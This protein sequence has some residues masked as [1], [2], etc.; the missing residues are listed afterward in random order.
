VL[1]KAAELVNTS[2]RGWLERAA[3]LGHLAKGAIYALVGVLALQ[4]ALGAGG[5]IAGNHEAFEL[6]GDQPFGRALLFLIAVGL[7]GYALWRVIEA[8]GGVWQKPRGG[9]LHRL[10]ALG[11]GLVNGALSVAV[12][13]MALGSAG[14][15]SSEPRS[16]VGQLL[17]QPFGEVALALVGAIIIGVGVFQFYQAYSKKFLE[18]FRLSKMSPDE[19]RWVTRAGQAGLVARGV[20]FPIVGAG[21]LRAAL[22]HDPSKTRDTRAA[23]IE[24]ASSAGGQIALALVAIGLLC[25]ALFM[26][27]SARYRQ[28]AC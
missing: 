17:Q 14:S 18:D 8:A 6:I 11:A 13:Q 24:I 28:I 21:F 16:W 2:N 4:V 26:V 15:G 9:A 3:R 1:T 10:G 22:E 25:F 20:V 7:A 12:F 5:R 19:Q 27:A 23:L